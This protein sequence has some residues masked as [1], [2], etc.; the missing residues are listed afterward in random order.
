MT[1]QSIILAKNKG[2]ILPLK[3]EDLLRV[4]VTGPTANSKSFTTGGWTWQWQGV[5]S[6]IEDK[7]FTYG[8]TV[9][10]AF[11]QQRNWQVSYSCGVDILGRNCDSSQDF[12]GGVP[13]DPGVMDKIKGWVGWNGQEPELSIERAMSFA[14]NHDVI[15]VCVGE[16][17]YTEKP[18][19]IRTLRLPD[20]QYEL[21]A[22]LRE[23]APNAKIVLVYFGGRPR[24]LAPIEVRDYSPM[25][26]YGQSISKPHLSCPVSA[27]G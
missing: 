15:V 6:N 20:G 23:A 14:A 2:N 10:D 12:H 19:D 17:N 16:E 13:Q 22:G 4:L 11:H 8:A 5:D 1:H 24:L 3:S 21:V 26:F 7:W 25:V 27:P 18:G 9:A